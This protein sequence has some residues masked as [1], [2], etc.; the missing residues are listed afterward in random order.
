MGS[1]GELETEVEI[2]FRNNFLD[3]KNCQELER[4]STRV[5]QLLERLHDSLD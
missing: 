4:I 5:S 3:R 1:Q 2:C